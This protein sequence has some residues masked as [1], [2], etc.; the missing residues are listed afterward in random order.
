MENITLVLIIVFMALAVGLLMIFYFKN[1][2]TESIENAF[3]LF[4]AQVLEEK[5]SSLTKEN[6][7]RVNVVLEPF[8]EQ[9]K[10]LNHQI[11]DLKK[12]QAVAKESFKNE[13]SKVIEQTSKF[14]I[15]AENLTTALKG[16]S[17]KQGTC[18]EMV[19][20]KTL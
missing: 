7:E 5:N 4:A 2:K 9:I 19:L 6:I 8:K 10:E 17:K 3:K 14:S 1:Q 15:D 18:G 20:E 16:D 11:S 12:E 13:V